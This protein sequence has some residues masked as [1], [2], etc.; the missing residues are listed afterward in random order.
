MLLRADYFLAILSQQH[1]SPPAGRPTAGDP[2]A[3]LKSLAVADDCASPSSMS[4]HE[5]GS[6]D[7]DCPGD[8]PN[9]RQGAARLSALLRP[10]S[11]SI[12]VQLTHSSV[13][14]GPA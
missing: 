1:L 13:A 12:G 5:D 3:A 2:S 10:V 14:R 9:R 7:E 11:E 6:K 4:R 8:D